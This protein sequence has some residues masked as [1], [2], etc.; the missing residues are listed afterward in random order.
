MWEVRCEERGLTVDEQVDRIV[1]RLSPYRPAIRKVVD[2]ID[3]D[4]PAASLVAASGM[5]LA[6]IPLLGTAIGPALTMG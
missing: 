4:V 2:E 1:A 6:F 5:L 3:V